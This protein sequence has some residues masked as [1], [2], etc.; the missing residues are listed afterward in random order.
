MDNATIIMIILVLVA[1]AA[2][3]I[4]F[5]VLR[6]RDKSALTAGCAAI[7][8]GL[9]VIVCFVAFQTISILT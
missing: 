5:G 6:E 8:V 4:I 2:G 9:F 1:L 3:L 7:T